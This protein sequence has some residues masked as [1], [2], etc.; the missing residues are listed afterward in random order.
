MKKDS[1]NSL[2]VFSVGFLGWLVP[3]AGYMYLG[4]RA[5]GVIVCVTICVT[6]FLGLLIGGVEMVD[7]EFSLPWFLAQ[8]M[9]GMPALAAF[10]LQDPNLPAGVGR[11][12]D[13]GQ[14]YTSVAGLLNVLCIVDSVVRALPLE[15]RKKSAP[16]NKG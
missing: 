3:G 15:K 1:T 8:V 12:I 4:L 10:A 11:G 16:M 5:R 7:P 2:K 14:L 6:F 9:A 13:M